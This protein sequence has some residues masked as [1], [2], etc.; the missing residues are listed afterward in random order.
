MRFIITIDDAREKTLKNLLKYNVDIPIV[1][2]VPAG[3]INR[4]LEG[5]NVASFELLEETVNKL[6]IEIAS[7]GY[8]H[9]TKTLST[10]DKTKILLKRII[11]SPDKIDMF[12]RLQHFFTFKG[13]REKVYN[14]KDYEKG[15]SRDYDISKEIVESKKELQ[16][17]FNIDI[18][19]YIYPGGYL[20]D[21]IL[22]LVS[23][24]YK[25]ARC[26][27]IGFNYI[28]D[29]KHNKRR[30]LLKTVSFSKF[31]KFEKIEKYY[32]KLIRLEKKNN[33]EMLII[34]SYHSL[35][36]SECQK[37]YL[38]SNEIRDFIKHIKNISKLGDLTTFK[39]LNI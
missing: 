29:L 3:L 26:S 21:E 28:E 5:E 22:N 11:S 16:K 30:Y 7:H 38:Y 13:T 2:G 37:N 32:E 12:M 35:V 1:I 17:L 31:T 4:K 9:I 36:D 23:K 8:Y 18:I 39:D 33:K 14:H 25:F 10:I 27:E 34:E 20:N 19:T 15:Y 6:N 24:N